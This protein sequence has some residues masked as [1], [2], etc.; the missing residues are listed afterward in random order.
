MLKTIIKRILLAI[1]M[2]IVMF[3]IFGFSGADGLESG[4]LSYAIAIWVSDVFDAIGVELSAEELHLPIRKLAHMSEYALLFITS[5]W[6]LLGIKKRYL[7]AACIS[8]MFAISDEIHQ[9]FVPGRA[10][11]AVDVLIDS[12]GV[13]IGMLVYRIFGPIFNKYI[14]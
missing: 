12:V 11:S 10:G 8:V 5:M 13:G 9:L 1:P 2:L 6:A 14:F 3:I 7:F 4:S